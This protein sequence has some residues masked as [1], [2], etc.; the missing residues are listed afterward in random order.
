MHTPRTAQQGFTLVEM[1]VAVT[2]FTIVMFISIG[3]LLTLT[4]SSSIAL[5]SQSV[6]SNLSFAADRISRNL[7]TGYY[8]HCA[9]AAGIASSLPEDGETND[10][11]N[12]QNAIVFTDGESGNRI[13][14]RYNESE[15]SVERK[16]E[17]GEWLRIN[18]A[19]VT[20]TDV[21]FIVSGTGEGDGVQPS[22][23]VM[24][25]AEPTAEMDAK[26][27]YYIQTTVTSFSQDF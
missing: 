20:M 9:T 21:A 7:R 8:Y 1:L 2:V 24:L 3:T 16:I 15:G 27:T 11:E 18:S 4:Q 17:S 5:T 22:V 12:G 10:C 6:T 26:P 14:F 19:D 13:G 25:E 23:T